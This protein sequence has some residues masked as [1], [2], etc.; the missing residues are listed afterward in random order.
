MSEQLVT[1]ASV[2]RVAGTGGA[3]AG[4]ADR[5]RRLEGRRLLC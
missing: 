1:R 2:G 5:E 3:A 4:T